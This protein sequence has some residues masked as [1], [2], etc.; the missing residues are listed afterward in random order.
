MADRTLFL[1]VWGYDFPCARCQGEMTWIFGLRPWYRPKVGELVT[2]DQ[3]LA[4]EVTRDILE[5]KGLDDLAAQLRPRPVR[6]RGVSFNPNTC[7]VCGDQADWQAL[8]DVINRALYNDFLVLARARVAVKR[9]REVIKERTY[10][11]CNI[12]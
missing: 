1:E 8:N 7:G 3:P 11:I 9:W 10:V 2:C 6:A 4:V 12:I 5:G